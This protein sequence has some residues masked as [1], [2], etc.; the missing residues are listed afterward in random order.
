MIYLMAGA[1]KFTVG[2][3]VSNKIQDGSGT[4]SSTTFALTN[5]VYFQYAY[6]TL[7]CVSDGNYW[8]LN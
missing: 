1:N 3:T 5:T 6:W 4:T 7:I 8:Y 2:C